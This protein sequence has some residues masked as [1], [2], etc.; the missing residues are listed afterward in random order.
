MPRPYVPVLLW[1]LS[2]LL[3]M[4][5]ETVVPELLDP[6][7]FLDRAHRLFWDAPKVVLDRVEQVACLIRHCSRRSLVVK[8]AAQ[9]KHIWTRTGTLGPAGGPDGF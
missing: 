1:M 7:F 8:G 6:V 2:D 3:Q 4:L 5:A 9:R